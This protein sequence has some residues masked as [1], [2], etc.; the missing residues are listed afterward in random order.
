MWGTVEYIC[1]V[2]FASSSFWLAA[3]AL[4]ESGDEIDNH[5]KK[6]VV[7]MMEKELKQNWIFSYAEL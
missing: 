3:L 7:G 6:N 2:E 1:L 5:F 4:E